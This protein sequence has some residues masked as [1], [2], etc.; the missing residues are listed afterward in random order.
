MRWVLF[1]LVVFAL[2][3][4]AAWYF[5]W[6]QFS[7]AK[8]E[9]DTDVTLRINR[10]QIK[11]D[12]D[13]VRG[14]TTDA[15]KEDKTKIKEETIRGTIKDARSD[16][17]T[18]ETTGKAMTLRITSETKISMEGRDGRPELRPGQEVRCTHVARGGE[19]VCLELVVLSAK[20]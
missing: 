2:A 10:D 13:R 12:I 18:L 19:N 7:V 9:H 8:G 11:S 20:K 17:V 3:F 5:N 6:I 4:T 15:V 1:T 16:R 14:G